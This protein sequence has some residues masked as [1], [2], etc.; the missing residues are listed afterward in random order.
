MIDSDILRIKIEM[1][2]MK[3]L[4]RDAGNVHRTNT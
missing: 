2:A 1:P 3:I 4:R